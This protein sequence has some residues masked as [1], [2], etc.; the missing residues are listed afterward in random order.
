MYDGKFEM[1]VSTLVNVLG[2]EMVPN[3]VHHVR[4]QSQDHAKFMRRDILARLAHSSPARLAE[5][6]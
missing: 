5:D 6:G 1:A 4:P 3:S 2:V